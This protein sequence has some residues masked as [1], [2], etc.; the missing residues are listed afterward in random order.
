[1][2]FKLDE[3][4]PWILKKVIETNKNHQVD[5]LYHENL[6]GITDKNLIKQC[7][8]ER[9]ILITHDNDFKNP[10]LFPKGSFYGIIILN[11]TKQGK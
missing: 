10:F 9:R 6:C 4:I 5:T 11:S 1:M 8:K 7:L 3:N 2:K